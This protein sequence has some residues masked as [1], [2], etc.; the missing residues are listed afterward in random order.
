MLEQKTI[1]MCTEIKGVDVETVERKT[2][3]LNKTTADPSL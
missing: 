3:N 2:V 1:N